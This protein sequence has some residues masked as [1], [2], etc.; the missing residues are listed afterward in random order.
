MG[1]GGID[2]G[3]LF[4]SSKWLIKLPGSSVDDVVSAKVV[5]FLNWAIVLSGLVAVIMIV[6]GGYTFITSAGNPEKVEKGRNVLVA[7]IIGMIIVFLARVI[8]E[9]VIDTFKEK[10]SF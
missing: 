10:G 5:P 1:E 8:V 7:A 3:S 9:L 6:Y 2:T 4:S